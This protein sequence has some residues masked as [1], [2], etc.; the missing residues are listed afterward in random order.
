VWGPRK[1]SLSKAMIEIVDG[2]R[3]RRSMKMGRAWGLNTFKGCHVYVTSTWFARK[4]VEYSK[5]KRLVE[6]DMLV[7]YTRPTEQCR[8]AASMILNWSLE[9]ADREELGVYA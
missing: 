8:G 6:M 3:N 1:P 7:L 5:P 4:V 2:L 9:L